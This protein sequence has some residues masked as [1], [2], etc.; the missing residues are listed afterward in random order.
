MVKQFF[1]EYDDSKEAPEVTATLEDAVEEV[2]VVTATLEDAV[3]EVPVVTA[4]LEDAVEET[5]ELTQTFEV[6]AEEGPDEPESGLR[7]HKYNIMPEMLPDERAALKASMQK[8]GYDK[9]NFPIMVTGRGSGDV[10]VDGWN[11]Y[12]VCQ[13]LGIEPSF[14][15]FEGSD[16]EVLDFV[17]RTNTR[18][19]LTPEQWA[20]LAVQNEEILQ[21][22]RKQTET[23]AAERMLAGQPDPTTSVSRVKKDKNKRT[24]KAIVAKKVNTTPKLLTAAVTLKEENPDEFPKMAKD[25]LSGETTM[26]KIKAS[27]KK[28]AALVTKSESINMVVNQNEADETITAGIISK[29]SEIEEFTTEKNEVIGQIPINEESEQAKIDGKFA[30]PPEL[31][32]IEE[33]ELT[34]SDILQLVK[35]VKNEV[36]GIAYL[37]TNRGTD[38]ECIE[39]NHRDFDAIEKLQL[40]LGIKLTGFQRTEL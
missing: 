8:N 27:K 14:K 35:K 40:D 30:T 7:K 2:P 11:R 28:S 38:K 16:E 24:T 32:E 39:V 13:E 3:E 21:T 17:M 12:K 25:I 20:V 29:S 33:T 10:I 5:P 36:K 37:I 4:T 31:L 6:A 1:H 34:D 26:R 22:I 15:L 9:L 18:R 23:E 19:N